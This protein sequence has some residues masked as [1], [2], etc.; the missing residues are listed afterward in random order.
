MK[1]KPTVTPTLPQ[2]SPKVPLKSSARHISNPSE[3]L[4][5]TTSRNST[6]DN[7]LFELSRVASEDQGFTFRTGFASRRRSEGVVEYV[8]AS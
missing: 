5:G 8:G 6:A 4:P 1:K 2:R 7:F 3:Y